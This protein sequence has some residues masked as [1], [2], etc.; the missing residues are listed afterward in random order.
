MRNLKKL[1]KNRNPKKYK[2]KKISKN[3]P[4]NKQ[5]LIYCKRKNM[6]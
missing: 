1:R 4:K 5:L 2:N 6:N 3:N